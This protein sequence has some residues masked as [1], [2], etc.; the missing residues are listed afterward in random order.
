MDFEYLDNESENVLGSLLKMDSVLNCNVSGTAIELLVTKGYVNGKDCRTL[1]DVK[2]RYVLIDITQKGKTYFELKQK[3][4]K[5]KKRL[6]RREWEI[7]IICALVGAIIG[8]IP[9]IIE[10]IK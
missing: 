2:P 4:E 1:S 8:L 7:A 9:S 6:S 5:E 3:Y 10:W